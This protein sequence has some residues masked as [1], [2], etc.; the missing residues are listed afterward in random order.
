MEIVGNNFLRFSQYRGKEQS[1][2]KGSDPACPEAVELALSQAHLMKGQWHQGEGC[3]RD[4]F[5]LALWT[6]V[7]TWAELSN[8]PRAQLYPDHRNTTTT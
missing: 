8:L 2:Q 5:Y 4:G 7:Q 1:G 6:L 3:T